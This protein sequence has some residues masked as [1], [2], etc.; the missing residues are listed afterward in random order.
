MT[1]N[2]PFGLQLVIDAHEPHVLADWWAQTL[3]WT[4]EPQDEAFIRSMIDQ[5]FASLDDTIEH[6][7]ALLWREGSAINPPDGSPTTG[8]RLLFQLVPESKSVKNRVH[9]DL[10][11]AGADAAALRARLLERG[12][13]A[14]GEG[15]Q[16]PHTWVVMTDPEGNEFVPD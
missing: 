7:G 8:L 9:L 1:E 5:G 13:S 16:G 4:V 3:N 12:A 10:R 11:L 14:I 2:K 6:N 15:V